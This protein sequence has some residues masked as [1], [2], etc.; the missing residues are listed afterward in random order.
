M[1]TFNY[2][3]VNTLFAGLRQQKAEHDTGEITIPSVLV[4]RVSSIKDAFDT[5][6]Y[7]SRNLKGPRIWD[8]E[9]N[10]TNCNYRQ[11]LD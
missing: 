11:V 4:K 10:K 5:G 1:M 7:E 3:L 2:H 9:L 8:S 6:L